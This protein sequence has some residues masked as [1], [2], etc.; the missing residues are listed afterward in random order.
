MQLRQ[1]SS[2]SVV[3]QLRPDAP[4]FARTGF[5][6]IPVEEIGIYLDPYR[7]NWLMDMAAIHT[8]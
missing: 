2:P 4:V 6:P 1:T 7:G 3:L 8:M 5:R